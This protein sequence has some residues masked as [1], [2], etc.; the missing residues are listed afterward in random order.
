MGLSTAQEKT[1]QSL[2]DQLFNKLTTEDVFDEKFEQSFFDLLETCSKKYLLED[3]NSPDYEKRQQKSLIVALLIKLKKILETTLEENKNNTEVYEQTVK[4]FA[5]IYVLINRFTHIASIHGCGEHAYS[6]MQIRDLVHAPV[7]APLVPPYIAPTSGTLRL[8]QNQ[9]IIVSV[10]QDIKNGTLS[11]ESLQQYFVSYYT[12]QGV[13][14]RIDGKIPFLVAVLNPVNLDEFA[15]WQVRE[16]PMIQN[17]VID[18]G[19]TSMNHQIKTTFFY[20]YFLSTLYQALMR[21]DTPSF[22]KSVKKYKVMHQIFFDFL[23]DV[24]P[25]EVLDSN[26]MLDKNEIDLI[27]NFTMT[28]FVGA[29]NTKQS[30]LNM[31]AV[32]K[33]Q[34]D[35]PLSTALFMRCSSAGQSE[36]D[37]LDEVEIREESSTLKLS[38]LCCCS[39]ETLRS[40]LRAG[41]YLLGGALVITGLLLVTASIAGVFASGGSSLLGL[42]VADGFVAAGLAL[43]L[44]G[45]TCYYTYT[46]NLLPEKVKTWLPSFNCPK[47][48]WPSFGD[49]FSFKG[50]SP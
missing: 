17:Q 43:I 42:F 44:G 19:F 9:N 40:F 12:K 31:V 8:S 25:K 22:K 37:D 10:I 39:S 27:A 49:V 21:E 16:T 36:L 23:K 48:S 45:E 47:M 20:R 2:V 29:N 41:A 32:K 15:L 7:S 28:N 6:E 3:L 4:K 24:G 46:G 30:P 1:N 33:N 34:P 38:L 18:F 11:N 26:L 50:F 14:A 35:C 5:K 13:A